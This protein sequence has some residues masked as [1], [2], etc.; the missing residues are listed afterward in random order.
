VERAPSNNGDMTLNRFLLALAL[1]AIAYSATAQDSDREPVAVGSISAEANNFR[2]VPANGQALNPAH[3]AVTD[4]YESD[5]NVFYAAALTAFTLN[6]LIII[7]IDT[8]Q[9]GALNRPRIVAVELRRAATN[10][11]AT[12]ATVNTIAQLVQGIEQQTAQISN[13]TSHIAES[14]DQAV[15][16]GTQIITRQDQ[17]KLIIDALDRE[18]ARDPSGRTLIN[19]VGLIAEKIGAI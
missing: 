19:L 4:S 5:N 1:V 17:V 7:T 12:A 16:Q 10:L 14:A 8:H 11:A 6:Q 15:A 3:C 18:I 13:Q 9:R 2:V